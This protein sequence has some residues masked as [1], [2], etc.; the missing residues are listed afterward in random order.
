MGEKLNMKT[1]LVGLLLGAGAIGTKDLLAEAAGKRSFTTHAMDVHTQNNGS[2]KVVGYVTANLALKDGGVGLVDMGPAPCALS[3][4]QLEDL[5][6]LM[7]T[8]VPQ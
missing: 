7:T 1:L 4:K 3:D 5:K 8:C 6:V 2:L